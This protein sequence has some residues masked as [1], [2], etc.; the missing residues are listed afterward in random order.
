[1]A[2]LGDERGFEHL[3]VF[4]IRTNDLNA[5]KSGIL[6]KE[7]RLELA[8]SKL[9]KRNEGEAFNFHKTLASVEF[10]VKRN[11]DEEKT[12]LAKWVAILTDLTERNKAER[13]ALNKQKRARNGRVY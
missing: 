6:A 1:M 10:Q 13:E 12:S 4:G 3:K 11:I 5:A 9:L 2:Q 8:E 7:T